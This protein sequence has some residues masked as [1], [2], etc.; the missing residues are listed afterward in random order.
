MR[1]KAEK[2]TERI[3]KDK[4]STKN[5]N[6]ISMREMVE[7]YKIKIREGYINKPNG[8]PHISTASEEIQAR[9]DKLVDNGMHPEQAA[10]QLGHTTLDKPSTK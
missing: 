5:V 4:R 7:F 6:P 1:P 2:V 9:F 8:K 3:K 10:K